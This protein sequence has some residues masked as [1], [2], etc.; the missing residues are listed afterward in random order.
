MAIR[1]IALAA[2]LLAAV[3]AVSIRG[4]AGGEA[5]A[6]AQAEPVTY[7]FDSVHSAALFRVHHLQ[8][9]QFW[10]RFN[11]L[12]GS[13]TYADGS[14]DTLSLDVR[15]PIESVDT[16]NTNLDNHLKSPDFFNAREY[17]VMSF[18]SSKAEKKEDRLY[19]VT[20]TLTILGVEREMTVPVE[21]TGSSNMRG[22]RCGLEAT[23]TIKRSDFGMKWGLDNGS[24]GDEVKI[25]VGMEG[26]AG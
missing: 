17:P 7:G 26:I 23:F 5:H 16:N 1:R 11:E 9:G 3:L 25:I 12:Q 15:I 18:K 19:H 10:G 20:G 6:A 14:E 2:S 21:W 4:D 8:A 13:F 22:R 24:V